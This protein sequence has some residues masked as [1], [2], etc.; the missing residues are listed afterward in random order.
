[1]E[2][3]H[4]RKTFCD[5]EPRARRTT[6]RNRDRPHV[7]PYL[8]AAAAEYY[9]LAKNL[10]G[11][12]SGYDASTHSRRR[13]KNSPRAVKPGYNGTAAN[14]AERDIMNYYNS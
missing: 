9:V 11:I 12:K 8:A 5:T 3:I 10:P 13:R 4:G 2:K 7:P 14:S 6:D 1:M